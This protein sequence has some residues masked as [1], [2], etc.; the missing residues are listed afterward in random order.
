MEFGFLFLGYLVNVG[1][2]YR[3]NSQEIFKWF[4]FKWR[5]LL[6]E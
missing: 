3:M 5:N 6:A 2:Q 4:L 1:A